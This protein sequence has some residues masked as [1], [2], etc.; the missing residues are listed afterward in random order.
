MLEEPRPSF[1]STECHIRRP[2]VRIKVVPASFG[3]EGFEDAI[4][5]ATE[6]LLTQTS[7][8]SDAKCRAVTFIVAA[9]D[10]SDPILM[11]KGKESPQVEFEPDR[12]R[13]FALTL[14]DKLRVFSEIEGAPSLMD[15]IELMSYHPLWKKDNSKSSISTA[16]VKIDGSS[17]H[18]CKYFPYPS[19]SVSMDVPV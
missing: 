3:L 15:E 17:S 9:P 4:W 10:L 11:E 12:F 6:D 7:S 19:V 16:I 1:S 14:R 18:G 5:E 8:D 13:S 2:L